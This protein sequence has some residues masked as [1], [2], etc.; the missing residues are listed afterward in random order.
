[1]AVVAIFGEYNWQN[2]VNKF[3]GNQGKIRWL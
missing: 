1:M 3:R 2:A